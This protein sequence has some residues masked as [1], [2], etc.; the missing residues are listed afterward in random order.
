MSGAQLSIYLQSLWSHTWLF[1][2][3]HCEF[4]PGGVI[5][6]GVMVN[7]MG[8][9]ASRP[10][11][12][13]QRSQTRCVPLADVSFVGLFVIQCPYLYNK[14]KRLCQ[15]QEVVMRRGKAKKKC[16]TYSRY[17]INVSLI[18]YHLYPFLTIWPCFML[19]FVNS[20]RIIKCLF[21]ARSFL[22]TRK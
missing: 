21:C 17:S 3:R 16:L 20:V 1:E 13:F 4:L 11:F 14:I 5:T 18:R 15:Y 8:P 6:C 7:L 22:R 19:S 2:G 10:A 12:K 9:G